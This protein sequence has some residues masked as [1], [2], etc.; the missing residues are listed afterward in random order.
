[1]RKFLFVFYSNEE[2]LLPPSVFQLQKK[3]KYI[4]QNVATIMFACLNC[5]WH[6]TTIIVL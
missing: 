5:F 4:G 1:M 6:V 3:E 2:A